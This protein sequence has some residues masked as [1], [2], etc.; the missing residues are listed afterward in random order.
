MTLKAF[1]AT[2]F[3]TINADRLENHRDAEEK[4]PPFVWLRDNAGPFQWYISKDKQSYTFAFDSDTPSQTVLLFK[5]T[6]G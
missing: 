2:S 6:F 4:S 1:E 5:L 3:A